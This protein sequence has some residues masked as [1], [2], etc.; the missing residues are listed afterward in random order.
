MK[1]EY[2][3]IGF[4]FFIAVALPL[5]IWNGLQGVDNLYMYAHAEDMLKNGFV[6]QYDIFSMHNHFSFSYQKWAACLLTYWIVNTFG[7]RG[8]QI[9][10]YL[11]G[12]MLFG[13]LFIF[14]HKYSKRHLFFI[15][16]VI[17][18]CGFLMESNG[19]IRFRPHV[20]AGIIFIWM[21]AVLNS[22][23]LG[24]IKA[25]IKFYMFFV[26]ASIGLMWVHST[27]WI[28]YMIVF[29]PYLCNWKMITDTVS[30]HSLPFKQR[31]YKLKPLY[32]SLILMFIAGVFNPN[33]IHQYAYMYSCLKATGPKYAHIDELQKIPLPAY[34]PVLVVACS[35]LFVLMHACYKLNAEIYPP[36]MYLIMGSLVLPLLSWRL[37]FYSAL[38]ITIAII[39]QLSFITDKNLALPSYVFKLTFCLFVIMF[40]FVGVFRHYQKNESLKEAYAYGTKDPQISEVVDWLYENAGS[41]L[42]IVTT[43]GHVGSYCIY[44]G[45]HPYTDCRAEVY[46]IDINHKRDILTEIHELS[47]D[48]FNGVKL[49]EGGLELFDKYYKPDYYVLTSYSDADMNLKHA[50]DKMHGYCIYSKYGVLSK[51][52]TVW[53]YRFHT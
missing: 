24:E 23:A 35:L 37:V 47:A 3:K 28:M 14:G 17:L 2:L 48:L 49:S 51:D 26:L 11:L 52:T 30:K 46:D 9:A 40:L 53:I 16:I 20:M 10:T 31:T 34:L 8:L 39:L 36:S 45:F 22:Y 25:D 21:F 13:S 32:I 29:L 38:F 50:L 18:S 43:T 19:T 6:R 4:L 44:R 12:A 33:G 5:F 1:H 15:T 41:D 42:S 7:W 27:M